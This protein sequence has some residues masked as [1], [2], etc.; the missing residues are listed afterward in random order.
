MPKQMRKVT[1]EDVAKEARVSITT[2]SR[3]INNVATV[4]EKNVEQVK[5]AVKRLNFS[6][7]PTAQRLASGRFNAIALIMPRFKGM[8]HSFYITQVIEGV[9]VGA[10]KLSLDLLLHITNDSSFINTASVDGIIFAD[11]DQ[12]E[13]QLDTVMD[14]E[15]PCV[16]MNTYIEELPI[17]C[18]AI[19][20]LN[21]AK[22][23]VH[24]LLELG[25]TDIATITGEL[26]IQAGMDRL[27]GY[28]SAL[29]KKGITPKQGYIQYG[30][31]GPDSAKE[32]AKR[33]LSM[34]DRPTAI[35]VASDM[36]ATTLVEEAFSMG[37]RVPEDLSVVGFDDS[38]LSSHGRIPLTSVRQ[39]L[40]EM[41]TMSVEILHRLIKG[42][43]KSP[44]KKLL[45]TQLIERASCRKT[46]IEI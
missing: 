33:L 4:K 12:N 10:D 30:D 37:L 20:N 31:F 36:M 9:G 21:G 41:G 35:F 3:V 23:A 42:K 16:V 13:E 14:K 1:I 5:Q 2:V 7:D 40:S 28:I 43:L 26:R 44:I 11:I 32:P 25:H 19:D 29:T 38:P 18:I 8:F 17:S 39:P 6:P 45:P 46:R 15:L 34:K 24:Y 22:E 27:N